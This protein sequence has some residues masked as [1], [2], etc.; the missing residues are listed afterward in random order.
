MSCRIHTGGFGNL[1][2]QMRRLLEYASRSGMP[3]GAGWQPAV[4]LYETAA[5]IVIVMELAGVSREHIGV[6]IDGRMVILKGRRLPNQPAGGPVRF[7]LM[8]IESG[9]FERTFRLTVDIQA[10]KVTAS[11][12]EGLLTVRLPKRRSRSGQGI[13]VKQG[14]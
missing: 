3:Q 9:H 4:D 12:R 11:T 14:R 10:K 5:E 8:E 2:G 6:V 1:S 13:E 7:H